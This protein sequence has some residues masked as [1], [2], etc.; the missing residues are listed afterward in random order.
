[1]ANPHVATLR[2][3]YLILNRD[4]E[5]ELRKLEKTTV[6]WREAKSDVDGLACNY[7]CG[8]VE[9]LKDDISRLLALV[10]P[11]KKK[12]VTKP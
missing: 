11:G 12:A 2:A 9:Q 6:K 1:M 4:L 8:R 5:N 3:L 10:P 7:Q